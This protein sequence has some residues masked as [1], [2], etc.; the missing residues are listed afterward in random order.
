MDQITTVTAGP[1]IGHVHLR[2]A[3]IERSLAFWRDI[4]GLEVMQRMPRA[5]FLSADGY[6]HHIAINNWDSEGGGPPAP[7]TTGLFHVALGFALPQYAPQQR[8]A[9][10]AVFFPLNSSNLDGAA[11]GTV[12]QAVQAARGGGVSGL[13][14]VGSAD[15]ANNAANRSLSSRRAQIVV[16]ELVRQGI[17]RSAISVSSSGGTGPVEAQSRRVDIIL[18]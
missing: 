8:G 3:D 14:V 18:R 16:A 12:S 10:F 1:R 4:I 5:V 17:P 6:H 11:R 13:D 15:G 2:V 7:G 9:N